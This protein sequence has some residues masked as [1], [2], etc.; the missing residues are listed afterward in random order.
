M[1]VER[2]ED[3]SVKA[4]DL[5]RPA[6]IGALTPGRCRCG[7]VGGHCELAEPRLHGRQG[8]H[9]RA[10]AQLPLARP[11]AGAEIAVQ[12]RLVNLLHV[13]KAVSRLSV[14]GGIPDVLSDKFWFCIQ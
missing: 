7:A 5:T 10:G 1:R 3:N 12:G 9:K 2:E 14:E 13:Q 8:A 4:P 11:P 6:M